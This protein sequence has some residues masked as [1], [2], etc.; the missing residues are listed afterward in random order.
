MKSKRLNRVLIALSCLS[1]LLAPTAQA[2]TGVI[3]RDVAL[4]SGG[5]LSGQVVDA[6]GA[7]VIQTPVSIQF[8]G[9][10]IARVVTDNTGKFSVSSLNGGVYQITA[11]GKMD[12][13]RCWAPNTAP[14]AAQQGLMLIS[15]SELV[16]AQN[17]GSGVCCGSAV[18]CGSGCCAGGGG[19][20]GWM[21]N[22]PVITAGAIGAAI[23]IPLATDDDNGSTS[24]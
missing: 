8:S 16:R 22:H 23:A 20:I 2:A 4:Q 13:Y 10:E 5:V 19:M 11:A 6:Q 15:D 18:G 12:F 1:M 7:P 21:A 9:K 24:P 17:C 3:P 14:P